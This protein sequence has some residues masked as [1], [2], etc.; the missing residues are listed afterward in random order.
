LARSSYYAQKKP[1]KGPGKRQQP[2][3]EAEVAAIFRAHRGR[4]GAPRIHRE[5]VAKGIPCS[6]GRVARAMK[7][8]KLQARSPLTFRNTSAANP[9]HHP[10]PNIVQRNFQAS[11]PNRLWVTDVTYIQT[12]KGWAYLALIMDM[13]CRTIVGWSLSTNC[14]EALVRRALEDATRHRKPRSGLVLHSDRGATYSAKNYRARLKELG[15]LQSM[16]RKGD[17]WDN[18][19][20]ESLNGTFKREAFGGLIAL[21]YAHA[22]AICSS[23]VSYYNGGRRHSG[24]GYKTPKQMYAAV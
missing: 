23:Y 22:Y 9:D 6:R 5:L 1:R 10:S 17:C 13:Y 16:S 18:A 4:Y 3:F 14:D 24:I 21:D 12:Q 15:I 8:L 2:R 11:E 7:S 20:A 19:P